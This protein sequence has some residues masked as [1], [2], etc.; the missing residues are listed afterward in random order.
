MSLIAHLS[1]TLAKKTPT[2]VVIDVQ[3]VGYAVCISL[4]TYEQ[5]PAEQAPVTLLTHHHIREER[6]SSSSGSAPKAN[7]IYSGS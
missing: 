4:S 2:D 1:G 5:L 3:G 6:V 7:A